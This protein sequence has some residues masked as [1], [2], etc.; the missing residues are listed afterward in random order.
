MSKIGI[1]QLVESPYVGENLQ[2]HNSIIL[3]WKLRKPEQGLAMGAPNFI[4]RSPEFLKGLP[5]NWAGIDRAPANGIKAALAADRDLP[6]TGKHPLL[7]PPRAHAELM[8]TYALL[9]ANHGLPVDGSYISTVSVNLLPTSRG[10]VTLSSSDPNSDLVIDPNYYATNTDKYLMRSAL[11][12]TLQVME[13]PAAQAFV[14]GEVAPSGYPTLTSNSSDDEID[15][16]V[17]QFSDCFHHTAG[18]ASMGKV[19]D[20]ELRVIGVKGLRVVDASV[21]PTPIAAHLQ[22]CIYALAEQA[23]DIVLGNSHG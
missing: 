9:G 14:E 20:T 2:D 23:S 10:R 7:E 16:R 22:A 4:T 12:R 17:R 18:T 21:V 8:V 11:R 1:P 5:F 3:N 6:K 19:V 13:T 15:A